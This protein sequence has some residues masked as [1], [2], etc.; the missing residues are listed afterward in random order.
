MKKLNVLII[1]DNPADII[2][3]EEVLGDTDFVDKL[4]SKNSGK[5]AI[6][7]LIDSLNDSG[8][9][10]PDLIFLDINMPIMDGHEVLG[11]I[12]STDELKHIPVIILTTSKDRRDINRAYKAYSN[13]YII[14]PDDY[15]EM[16]KAIKKIKEF[17]FDLAMLPTNDR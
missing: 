2:L 3:M 15:S 6:S 1:D 5:E 8:K 14:K 12:K 10:L 11:I 13:S 4:Y 17:W 16:D 7:F 9:S